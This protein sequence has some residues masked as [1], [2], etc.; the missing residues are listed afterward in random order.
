MRVDLTGP[1]GSE[2]SYEIPD[3]L[4]T[5]FHADPTAQNHIADG[6]PDFASV[7]LD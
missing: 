2:G 4:K 7:P 5:H 3:L 1:G 6:R